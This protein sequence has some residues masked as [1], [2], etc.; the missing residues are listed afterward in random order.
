MSGFG[1]SMTGMLHV[2]I[3]PPAIVQRQGA[4][5]DLVQVEQMEVLRHASFD[6]EF[7]G[8]R[9]LLIA[10]ERAERYDGETLVDGLP[11]RPSHSN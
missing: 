11:S 2:A 10:S 4:Q 6:Y 1:S 5:W 9:Y 3:S 7:N 8:P